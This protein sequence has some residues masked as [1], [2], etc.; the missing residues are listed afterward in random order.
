M[1][2]LG[3]LNF[4][5][6]NSIQWRCDGQ[7]FENALESFKLLMAEASYPLPSEDTDKAVGRF[8]SEKYP[9]L[10]PE[11][12]ANFLE[13]MRKFEQRSNPVVKIDDVYLMKLLCETIFRET[14]VPEMQRRKRAANNS[15]ESP[16]SGHRS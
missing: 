1:D 8:L 14:I 5:A 10:D 4:I 3:G 2:Y 7:A 15:F 11:H 9:D 6:I 13:L 16:A 12:H